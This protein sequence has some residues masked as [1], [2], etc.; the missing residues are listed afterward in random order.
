MQLKV[1]VFGAGTPQIPLE[2]NSVRPLGHQSLAESK[3]PVAIVVLG[4][5]A[6]CVA[7]SIGRVV[8]GA[9]VVHGPIHKLEMAVAAHAIYV[10]K[11]RNAELAGAQLDASNRQAG[12]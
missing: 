8:I 10:E 12:G 6:H 5:D 7:A 1:E 9:V 2:V 4:D 11:I 3:R